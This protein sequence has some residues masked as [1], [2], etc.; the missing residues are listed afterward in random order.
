MKSCPYCKRQLSNNFLKQRAKERAT[1]ISL[2]LRKTKAEGGRIGRN[3]KYDYMEIVALRDKGLSIREIMIAV[4]A[5]RGSVQNAL[6]K[7][8]ESGEGENER[9]N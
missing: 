5:S 9:R 3:R 2:G 8:R 1:A 4:G 7:R 6:R